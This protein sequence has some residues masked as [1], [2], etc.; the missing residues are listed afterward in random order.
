M[1][2]EPISSKNIIFFTLDAI[3]HINPLLSIARELKARGHNVCMLTVRKLKIVDNFRNTGIEFQHCIE[4]V[5]ETN[6]LKIDMSRKVM[7]SLKGRFNSSVTESFEATYANDGACGKHVQDI[8]DTHDFI[9][10]K[11]KELKPDLIIIDNIIGVPCATTSAPKW[12]RFYSGYPIVQYSA[13]NS[14]CSAG[15][16]LKLEEMDSTEKQYELK[17]KASIIKKI[18]EFFIEKGIEPWESNIELS[19]SSPFLNFCL[20][21]NELSLENVETFKQLDSTWIRLEHTIEDPKPSRF[22]IP[23]SLDNQPGKLIYLSLGTLVSTDTDLINRLLEILSKSPNKFIVSKG[24]MSD[25]IKMYPNMWGEAYLDQKAILPKVDL[26]ITHGGHNS[27]IEA[28]YYGV[29]GL[30]VCPVFA[31]QFDSAQRVEDLGFGVRLNPFDCT[32]EQLL[33]SIDA[34][35]NNHELKVKMKDI[36]VRMRSIEYHKIAADHLEHLLLE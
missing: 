27:I 30:I 15:R 16:G 7:E 25:H 23:A 6:Q 36:G 8:I 14:N 26:F 2:R 11:M 4:D 10:K 35:L 29:P 32:E 1:G 18:K 13:L 34:L 9:E 24:Q 12:A 33:E 28:F 21:P 19:P 17:I 22:E 5:P 20:G 3:G 31:D